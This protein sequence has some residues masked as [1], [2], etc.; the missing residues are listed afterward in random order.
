[1]AE[2]IKLNEFKEVNGLTK[3]LGLD[4]EGNSCCV[5]SN[6][7]LSPLFQVK[8]T[9][10]KNLNDCTDTGI[11]GINRDI[12]NIG[13]CNYGM[14]IVFNAQD[15]ANEGSPIVQFIISSGGIIYSRMKWHVDEWTG[16]REISFT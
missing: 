3:I 7:L 4:S 1:M 6:I 5:L 10:I 16:W 12:Y 15:T 11:Y 9:V 14:L 8:G 13:I 2:D